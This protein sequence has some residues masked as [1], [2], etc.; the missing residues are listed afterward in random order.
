MAFSN[1]KCRFPNIK[2]HANIELISQDNIGYFV[3]EKIKFENKNYDISKINTN[4]NYT[5]S[6]LSKQSAKG[7]KVFFGLYKINGNITANCIEPHF[8]SIPEDDSALKLLEL[9]LESTIEF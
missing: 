5:A 2:T 7:V 9:D 1:N 6:L 8:E 4:I 3:G